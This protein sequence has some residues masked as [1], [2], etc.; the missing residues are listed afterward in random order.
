MKPSKK[1]NT[2]SYTH[3]IPDIAAHYKSSGS[4]ICST[5]YLNNL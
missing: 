4:L 3:K 2:G 1:M 5:Y